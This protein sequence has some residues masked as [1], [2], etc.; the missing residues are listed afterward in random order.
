MPAR[1]LR[2]SLRVARPRKRGQR[3][4][5]RRPP[6]VRHHVRTAAVQ[7]RLPREVRD[8]ARRRV[9]HGQLPEQVGA[10]VRVRRE[11]RDVCEPHRQRVCDL[12]RAAA[13]RD[14]HRPHVLADAG[15]LLAQ[16]RRAQEVRPA[17]HDA[18]RVRLRPDAAHTDDQARSLGVPAQP[19][20][21]L[22][23]RLRG[24][25]LLLP[26]ARQREGAGRRRQQRRPSA[27]LEDLHDA[28]PRLPQPRG[29]HRDLRRR[30]PVEQRRRQLRH[31]RARRG[32]PVDLRARAPVRPR[33][34]HERDARER[35]LR[36]QPQERVLQHL[37][38]HRAH[39]PLPL[40]RQ[41]RQHVCPPQRTLQRV[42]PDV[43]R[44]HAPSDGAA[45]DAGRHHA[46]A[47]AAAAGRRHA[48]RARPAAAADASAAA[49][50]TP[51]GTEGGVG[52]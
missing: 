33:P 27:R 46:G 10:A 36:R 38:G 7:L 3:V 6:H 1:Q 26:A 28:H 43:R 24:R 19:G 51:A 21:Q 5:L 25:L 44:R 41:G 4:V 11:Q 42:P 37:T 48:A 2:H 35:V 12:G 8:E 15:Y 16:A 18:L 14:Q 20:D 13:Q 50:T 17:R 45:E 32:R 34:H 49:A 23:Q 39:R 9:L 52:Q 29:H 47:D 31:K 40:L 22:V 30:Q